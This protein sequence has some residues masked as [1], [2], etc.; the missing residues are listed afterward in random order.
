MPTPLGE[1]PGYPTERRGL[2]G[3]VVSA[4]RQYLKPWVERYAHNLYLC[5][6]P[7]PLYPYDPITQA[8]VTGVQIAPWGGV[9]AHAQNE[10]YATYEYAMFTVEYATPQ[11]SDPQPYPA[12]A[13]PAKHQDITC[14][15]SEDWTSADEG[16][17][18]KPADFRWAADGAA[19]E[20]DE[21]PFLIKGRGQY[22]LTRHNLTVVPDIAL[23]YANRI[24]SVTVYPILISGLIFP[25]HTLFYKG[26]NI[27]QSQD[28]A[29]TAR[30]QIAMTFLYRWEGWR[31]FFRSTKY[32][33]GVDDGYDTLQVKSG[34]TT[35]KAW[36]YPKAVD[37][38]ALQP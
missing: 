37:L 19:I 31:Y 29:G 7:P 15:I 10:V 20:N 9:S 4:T 30:L 1:Q 5:G 35:W 22:T 24:N 17:Q 11:A 12:A 21:V 25:I 36:A 27:T 28:S 23:T 8:R 18:L 14:V 2:N 32:E 6:H 26:A 16:L 33:E 34:P 13:N 3:V 38:R